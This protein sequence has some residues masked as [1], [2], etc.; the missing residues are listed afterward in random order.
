MSDTPAPRPGTITFLVVLAFLTGSLN[1]VRGVIL[2]F[3]R[4][5]PNMQQS[6]AAGP[7]SV[8]WAGVGSIV[9]GLV[10]LLVAKGLANANGFSR[11][12]VGF[13]SVL[14]LVV[15]IYGAVTN[16]EFERTPGIVGATFSLIM[17]TLLYTNR[18]NA[19]FR[20]N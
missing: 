13:I 2:V 18:A 8:F 6:V 5:E 19:F 10:V 20:T 11:F 14:N 3:A 12:L 4:N 16:T 15:G 1:V 17:L 7:I 9:A